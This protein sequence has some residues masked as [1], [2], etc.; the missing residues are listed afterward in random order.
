MPKSSKNQNQKK[1]PS[2]KSGR[3]AKT[4]K[5]SQLNSRNKRLGLLL[6]IVFFVGF[7]VYVVAHSFAQSPSDNEL[8]IE[9]TKPTP[10]IGNANLNA[11]PQ[12]LPFRLYHNGLAI[13]GNDYTNPSK[14]EPY[15]SAQL[16]STQVNN[17]VDQL[18]KAGL[19]NVSKIPPGLPK[20]AGDAEELTSTISLNTSAGLYQVDFI[21]NGMAK[22]PQFAQAQD[23]IEK[24]CQT[25]QAPYQPDK[26]QVTTSE[27]PTVNPS[28]LP[29]Q[30]PPAVNLP[31][32]SEQSTQEVSGTQ[33]IDLARQ[34]GNRRQKL[35]QQD[36]RAFLTSVQID[37]PATKRPSQIKNDTGQ[38]L[39]QKHPGA[40]VAEAATA[41][42]VTVNLF[43][44]TDTCVSPRMPL[45]QYQKTDL[46]FYQRLTGKVFNQGAGTVWHGKH[47]ASYYTTCHYDATTCAAFLM[48]NPSCQ[49]TPQGCANQPATVPDTFNL[50]FAN[51]ADE[52]AY[53]TTNKNQFILGFSTGPRLVCGRGFI[54]NFPPGT[55]G[56]FS[57]TDFSDPDPGGSH[58]CSDQKLSVP[59]NFDITVSAHEFGHNFG[60][61]HPNDPNSPDHTPIG[62][63]DYG[64]ENCYFP[65]NCTLQPYQINYLKTSSPVFI[66]APAQVY[67]SSVP[68]LLALGRGPDG[69]Q[70]TYKAY[71]GSWTGQIPIGGNLVTGVSAVS[72]ARGRI[73][74]FG[75]NSAGNLIHT[76]Y[77]NGKWNN[78][79]ENLG[80]VLSSNVAVTSWAAGRLDVFGRGSNNALYHKAYQSGVGWSGWENLGGVLTSG[81]SV[82]TWGPGRLDVFVRGGSN[83]LYHKVYNGKW[84]AYENLGGVIT[85]DPSAV[86]WAPGR[87]DVFAKAGANN[88]YHKVYNGKW[89]GWENLGGV[90]LDAP[91]AVSRAS[92]A[93]DVFVRGTNSHLYIKSYAFGWTGFGDLGAIE[94]SNVG[95]V[96]WR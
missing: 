46:V 50:T 82:T 96:V 74:V 23:V 72:W 6:F 77:A 71:Q 19:T 69:H 36:G 54:A 66:P 76:V 90:I 68:L 45:D 14:T 52:L 27:A 4:S 48:P 81:P 32:A 79:W 31:V 65:D 53:P 1:S 80:G 18:K 30:K 29:D 33:A 78:I 21:N 75:V 51:M 85:S 84:N 47:P 93:L 95:A 44:A 62:I 41:Y 3:A 5:L 58:T 17:L 2:A 22:R 37:L 20:H 94:T 39:S 60:L 15:Y 35:Y 12:T 28:G 56:N 67:N 9:Y 70:L 40:T 89:N 73:D 55:A 24:F 64:Q 59:I 86:A 92:G 11:P 88:L 26:V 61:F 25:V 43:C 34:F 91:S 8:V 87:I 57:L 16:T 7:G 38:P 42:P 10:L 83:A 63:M 13:C 49:D